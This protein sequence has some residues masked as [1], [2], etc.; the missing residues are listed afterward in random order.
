MCLLRGN[1]KNVLINY[2]VEPRFKKITKSEINDK[3]AGEEE[4]IG[5]DEVFRRDNCK[6]KFWLKTLN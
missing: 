3:I 4:I 2:S 5:Y 6:N 1:W